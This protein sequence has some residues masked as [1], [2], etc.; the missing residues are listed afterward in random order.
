M[1]Y[2]IRSGAGYV[3]QLPE[4]AWA[5][6]DGIPMTSDKNEA[7]IFDKYDDAF[8][9]GFAMLEL[10]YVVTLEPLIEKFPDARGVNYA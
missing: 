3:A 1:S 2:L 4:S 7:H 9:F 10:G 6:A 5:M 8:K